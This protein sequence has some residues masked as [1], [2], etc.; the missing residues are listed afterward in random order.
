MDLLKLTER[1]AHTLQCCKHLKGH[2][3]SEESQR[4]LA[5][6][7]DALRKHPPS[8][9]PVIVGLFNQCM[10]HGDGVIDAIASARASPKLEAADRL[11][12]SLVRLQDSVENLHGAAARRAGVIGNLRSASPLPARTL[13]RDG[14]SRSA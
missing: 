7:L 3:G 12:R 1:S 6:A 9:P 10:A 14:P 8:A 4:E 11:H 2:V 5:V 13:G